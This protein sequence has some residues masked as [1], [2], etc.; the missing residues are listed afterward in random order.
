MKTLFFLLSGK[1]PIATVLVFIIN[2]FG[3]NSNTLYIKSVL[4]G[5]K[6]TKLKQVLL[7]GKNVTIKYDCSIIFFNKNKKHLLKKSITKVISY[8]KIA[9]KFIIKKN[10]NEIIKLASF[11][12]LDEKISTIKIK[13]PFAKELK[14]FKNFSLF[15]K[16]SLKNKKIWDYYTPFIKKKGKINILMLF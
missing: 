5:M 4:K 3:F 11:S 16:A 13:F 6:N 15:I 12:E 9:K 1:K 14:K 8:N 2:F 7:T 10:N